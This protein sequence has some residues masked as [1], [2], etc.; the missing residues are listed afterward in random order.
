MYC[1]RLNN[2]PVTFI[3][4]R[5]F[6]VFTSYSSPTCTERLAFVFSRLNFTLP[7]SQASPAWL[8]VLN[9]LIAHKYLSSLSFF[10]FIKAKI[11]AFTAKLIKGCCNYVFLIF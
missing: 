10:F 2:K 11:N 8:R 1:T 9:N 3:T 5:L 6:S 4:Q 7:L